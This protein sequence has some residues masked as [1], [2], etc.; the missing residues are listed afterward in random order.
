MIE[1]HVPLINN[2]GAWPEVWLI[3]PSYGRFNLELIFFS[4]NY[5]YVCPLLLLVVTLNTQMTIL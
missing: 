4:E 5:S 1:E 2:T 3:A